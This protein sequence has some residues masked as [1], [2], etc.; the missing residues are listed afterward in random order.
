M[1]IFIPF[2]WA[3]IR[4]SVLNCFCVVQLS[5]FHLRLIEAKILWMNENNINTSNSRSELKVEHK[6]EKLLYKI[7]GVLRFTVTQ[8]L[9]C[10]KSGEMRKNGN[11]SIHTYC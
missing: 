10:T 6:S 1:C 4:C 11:S 3:L 2:K 5:V 7:W 9:C 8:N